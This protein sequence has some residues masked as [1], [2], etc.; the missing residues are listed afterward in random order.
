VSHGRV[1]YGRASH[2][3]VPHRRAS[4]GCG[5]HW[6]VLYPLQ[7]QH[8]VQPRRSL[9]GRLPGKA[10]S[11]KAGRGVAC[12]MDRHV[13]GLHLISMRLIGMHLVDVHLL[14]GELWIISLTICVRSTPHAH[15]NSLPPIPCSSQSSHM[16][17]NCSGLT[18][19]HRL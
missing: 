13:W 4:P 17:V 2:G 3:H 11:V 8:L 15:S 1:P 14:Q 18:F 19:A 16:L 6:H 7:G 5:F 10:N 9:G 12:A